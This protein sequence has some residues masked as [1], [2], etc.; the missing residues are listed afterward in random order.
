[1]P[2][3]TRERPGVDATELQR[4]VFT[5]VLREN[6]ALPAGQE[7][8]LLPHLNVRQWN[9]LHFHISNDNRSV[10]GLKVRILFGTPMLDSPCGELLADSTLWFEDTASEREF[11]HITP[12]TYNG[13]GF[14]MSVPVV[15]PELVDV[16]LTNVSDK[17]LE[18]LYVTVMAQE[19]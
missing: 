8:R 19:I 5:R 16:I 10:A 1:M 12:D 11:S 6:E 4:N 3:I 7:R 17:T 2:T 14:E 9:R 18:S 15:A 13:T